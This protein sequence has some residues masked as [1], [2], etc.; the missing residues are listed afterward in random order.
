MIG[1]SPAKSRHCAVACAARA[2]AE[3]RICPD[4]NVFLVV[5]V[6]AMIVLV[7]V[8]VAELEA[9]VVPVLARSMQC[10]RELRVWLRSHMRVTAM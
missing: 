6:D 8:A 4:Q 7:V 3:V 1:R 5:A 10:M 9:C 2:A